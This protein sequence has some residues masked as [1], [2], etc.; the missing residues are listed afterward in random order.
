MN[1]L[2]YLLFAEAGALTRTKSITKSAYACKPSAS[3]PMAGNSLK[4]LLVAVESLAREASSNFLWKTESK[5]SRAS[6]SCSEGGKWFSAVGY[7]IKYRQY[8][9][10]S[11]LRL[12]DRR[13][14]LKWRREVEPLLSNNSVRLPPNLGF[15]WR[16]EG[17]IERTGTEASSSKA[18]KARGYNRWY[19]EFYYLTNAISRLF[20]PAHL[21]I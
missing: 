16:H 12:S 19:L 11:Y 13:M 3:Q 8:W 7:W 4:N 2:L 15:L 5:F 10:W 21:F 14:D 18:A 20:H 1:R 6:R 17:Q 9:G